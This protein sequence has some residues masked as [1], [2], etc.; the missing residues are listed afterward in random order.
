MSPV[1]NLQCPYFVEGKCYANAAVSPE[2]Y[3]SHQPKCNGCHREIKP[4]PKK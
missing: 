2:E 4:S 3:D 1:T